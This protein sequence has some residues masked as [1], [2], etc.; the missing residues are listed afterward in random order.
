[1]EEEEPRGRIWEIEGRAAEQERNRGETGESCGR[2]KK[3][4]AEERGE[5][6]EEKQQKNF[7]KTGTT[8]F[9]TLLGRNRTA[10]VQKIFGKS[11]SKSIESRFQISGSS[12]L[13][14]TAE[15]FLD[16][17]SKDLHSFL[18]VSG[19]VLELNSILR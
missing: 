13:H 3:E 19:F 8:G 6:N 11:V 17:V 18:T 1:M 9:C 15:G 16:F 4:K 14:F 7:R 5:K 2:R 12:T 10:F